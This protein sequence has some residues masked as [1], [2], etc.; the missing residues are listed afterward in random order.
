MQVR[1]LE[2]VL[3]LLLVWFYSSWMRWMGVL[4]LVLVLVL[5]LQLRQ[6]VLACYP[7]SWMRLL[8]L[9]VLLLLVLV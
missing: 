8:V 7:S 5:V 1:Q 2:W 9:L 3:L 6:Q 4:L